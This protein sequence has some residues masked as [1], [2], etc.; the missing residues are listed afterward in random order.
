MYEILSGA[1]KGLAMLSVIL[2]L[3]WTFVVLAASRTGPLK[4]ARLHRLA[5]VG[6]MASTGLVAITGLAVMAAGSWLATAFPWAGLVA[7]AGHGI[8]GARSRS[9]LVAGN[10]GAAIGATIF[11]IA[12]LFVAYGLMTVKPF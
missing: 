3:C 5:Y 11:Q 4:L 10:G 6:A 2:T 7:V 12:L 9:A 1:H 8:A